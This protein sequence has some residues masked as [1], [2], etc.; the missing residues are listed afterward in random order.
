MED[1][2]PGNRV[3]VWNVEP[4]NSVLGLSVPKRVEVQHSNRRGPFDGV[5]DGRGSSVSDLGISLSSGRL[6]S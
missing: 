2:P 4:M 6:G 1:R 3:R 5:G